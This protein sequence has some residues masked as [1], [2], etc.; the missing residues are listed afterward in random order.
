MK[1]VFAFF[2]LLVFAALSLTSA[3]VTGNPLAWLEQ[4]DCL[5]DIGDVGVCLSVTVVA[6]VTLHTDGSVCRNYPCDRE[7]ERHY[8]RDWQATTAWCPAYAVEQC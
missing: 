6:P 7:H 3:I 1:T 4:L 8:T 5:I 2:V